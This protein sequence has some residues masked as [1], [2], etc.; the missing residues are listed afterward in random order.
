[1][2]AIKKFYAEKIE[3][4]LSMQNYKLVC[5]FMIRAVVKAGVKSY[6]D[7][8]LA[9]F[10]HDRALACRV[11][12]SCIEYVDEATIKELK[13][14][15]D[16]S[17][18]YLSE[19]ICEIRMFTPSKPLITDDDIYNHLTV[20]AGYHLPKKAHCDKKYLCDILSGKKCAFLETHFIKVRQ[21]SLSRFK[22]CD[23]PILFGAESVLKYCPVKVWESFEDKDYAFGILNT[24]SPLSVS[25]MMLGWGET[26]LR[27]VMS[28]TTSDI[29]GP[30]NQYTSKPS[31]SFTPRKEVAPGKDIE[32]QKVTLTPPEELIKKVDVKHSAAAPETVNATKTEEKKA[33]SPPGR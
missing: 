5:E 23:F 28:G 27:A 26:T 13:V 2:D 25:N 14:L 1:M 11:L 10:M 22:I 3:P 17:M 21:A 12:R 8:V 19:V 24:I 30:P 7:L 9:Y 6:N 18:T 15:V 16:K 4:M 33:G 31:F 32:K 20:S 29:I